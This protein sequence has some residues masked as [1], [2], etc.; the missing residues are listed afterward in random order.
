MIALISHELPS[1]Q[2]NIK[3]ATHS[4]P[5]QTGPNLGKNLNFVA[6]AEGKLPQASVQLDFLL[7]L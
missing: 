4:F 5:P 6:R 2:E 3:D 7:G 1:S